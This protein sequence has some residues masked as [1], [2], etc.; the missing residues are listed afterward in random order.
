MAWSLGEVHDMCEPEPVE[1]RHA[2]AQK[3]YFG[4]HTWERLDPKIVRVGGRAEL[5]LYTNMGV[6]ERVDRR[7]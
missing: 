2:I 5:D 3:D 6:H 7:L 1:L 4:E